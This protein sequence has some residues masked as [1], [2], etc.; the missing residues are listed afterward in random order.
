MIKTITKLI[1]LIVVLVASS[2]KKNAEVTETEFNAV[3]QV[4]NFYN[5]EVF[6]SKGFETKDGE[7]KNYFGLELSK[8]KLIE[9]NKTR[10]KSHAGNIAYLFYSNLEH[11][12][13]N[14][15]QVRVKIILKDGTTSESSF[16]SNEIEEI[17][18]L[19]PKIEKVNKLI[20]SKDYD[21]LTNSFDKSIPLAK[22]VIEKLF[23]GLEN[24]YGAVKKSEFQG[25]YPKNTDD[26]GEVIKVYIAQVRQGAALSMI[27]IFKK[28]NK[29]L[30]SIKFE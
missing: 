28:T 25:F 5:G 11:E 6:R 20:E 26:F 4:L 17:E 13:S 3:Q 21:T 22:S 2:C 16:S 1:I 30:I 12:K 10:V 15:N 8:S 7:T 27:L 23:I 19:I 29:E 24:K 14:Y 9:E 18:N